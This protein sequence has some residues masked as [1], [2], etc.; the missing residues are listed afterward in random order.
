MNKKIRTIKLLPVWLA[1]SAVVLIAGIILMAVLGFNYSAENPE[2]KTFEVRY[3]VVT[4]IAEQEEALQNICETAFDNAGIHYLDCDTYEETDADTLYKTE[5]R[6]LVYTFSSSVSSET[7][8]SVKTAVESEIENM[9][10]ANGEMT[11]AEIFVSTHTVSASEGLYFEVCWRGALA[12]FV[13]VFVGLIYTAIRFGIG[14]A[15]TGLT[16]SVHDGAVT[17]ALFALLRI[18][19]YYA[20]PFTFAAIASLVSL[21]LWLV[22][23]MKLKENMKQPGFSA[24]AAEE[25]VEE[26]CKTSL[27]Y[28]LSLA[29][30][31]GAVLV[32]CGLIATA[33]SRLFFLPAL[34][35]V[36]VA[37]YS[38]LLF[39]PALHVYVKAAFDRLKLKRARHAGRKKALKESAAKSEE[40]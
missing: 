28:V 21:V 22:Q 40:V 29:G 26:S 8:E 18:P 9:I 13:A 27:R 38:S 5:S 2:R 37:V 30:G 20:M 17:L 1:V 25:A 12:V 31:L 24:Y 32:V 33:G 7:L 34:I 4:Q 16:V 11:N 6:R 36:A 10:S 15:L 23:C 3:D 19:T 39:G 14:S 35:P